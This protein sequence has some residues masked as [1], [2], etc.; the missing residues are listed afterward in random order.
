MS[1][2]QNEPSVL[3]YLKERWADFWGQDWR[4]R[5]KKAA[6]AASSA[7]PDD[8]L[9][10]D[11]PQEAALP[12]P[13]IPAEPAAPFP[14]R[15]A[16]ALLLGLLAQR[17]LE[18]PHDG[19]APLAVFLYLAA[20]GLVTWALLRGEL[21]LPAV[22]PGG[23]WHDSGAF[24]QG[25]LPVLGV[26]TLAAFATFGEG[27]FTPLNLTLWGLT[28]V[29]FWLTFRLPERR[30]PGWRNLLTPWNALLLG[31]AALVIFFRFYRLGQVPWE[32][33]SD[34]AE[35]LYDI[36]DVA[37]G[38]WRVFF[39]RN[40]G[41]EAFQFYWTL[42]VAKIFGT[43][44]SY[45]SLKIGTVLIGLIPLPYVYK[46]GLEWGNRRLA[47]LA[48]F[49]MGVA[50]WPNLIARM[51]LRFPLYP[52]FTAPALFH[53]F[54][55]LRTGRRNDFIWSGVFLGIGLHGYSP[56]RVVPLLAVL[57][58]AIY[59]WH[60][61]NREK[62]YQALAFFGL[63]VLAAV[64]VFLPLGRYVLAH[65]DQ[66]AYRMLTRMT[67]AEAPLPGPAWKIFLGNVWRGLLM[68]NWDDGE[69]WAISVPHRPAL[70]IVSGA[71]FL[72]GA[73]LTLLRYL[74]ERSWQDLALLLSIPVLQLSS[75]LAL[76]FPRENPALNRAGGAA[77]P[78]FL[79]AAFG[80]DTLLRALENSA[81]HVRRRAAGV[82][83]VLLLAFSAGQNYNLLFHTFA[84]QYDAG[85]WNYTEM[86]EVIRRFAEANDAWDR[87]WIVPYPYW[88]DTR[89]PALLNGIPY[90]D[91]VK[92]RD[93]LPETL[94]I[95]APKLFLV[96]Y[97]DQETLDLLRELYPQGILQHYVPRVPYKDFWVF[98]VYE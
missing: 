49:L 97:E 53:L 20:L 5:W 77:I 39:P 56:F 43:G 37:N 72:L 10:V 36:Y 91:Y 76:A 29:T 61:P 31:T 90:G 78:V 33:F 80:L 88:A 4:M 16:A 21:H 96:K 52:A 45:M 57:V 23:P 86:A 58:L 28:L 83:L 44:I 98:Y 62:R 11:G 55:G 50:Y 30:S 54:R 81:G 64:L 6:A 34:H 63:L 69:I 89:L 84:E 74:R 73:W 8:H 38:H 48:T 24:R 41:R 47:W 82:L 79:L 51:G 42:L 65:P 35:K 70:G 32:P 22:P 85:T 3:D 14:W 87:T 67:D 60:E 59:L 93:D 13:I 46:L 68:F 15:V 71:F 66:F 94:A 92:W 75:T 7:L 25:L 9:P 1:P 12:E 18:P 40:T 17:F 95:P 27:V 26:L 19:G 2:V